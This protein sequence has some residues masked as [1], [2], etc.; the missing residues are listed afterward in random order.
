M[1][2]PLVERK[3]LPVGRGGRDLGGGIQP[4]QSGLVAQH[5]QRGAQIVSL[6]AAGIQ[7]PPLHEV[8]AEQLIA[9]ALRGAG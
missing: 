8:P 5:L 4:L 6:Q 2:L 7:G 3:R 9:V 1:H